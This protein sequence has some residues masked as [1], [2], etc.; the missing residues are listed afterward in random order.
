ML[1]LVL[2]NIGGYA[3][4]EVVYIAVSRGVVATEVAHDKACVPLAK[5]SFAESAEVAGPTHILQ[6]KVPLYGGCVN[7][8]KA[9]TV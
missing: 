6:D 5:Q 3:V 2:V 7:E 1:Q 9:P 8:I 4:D